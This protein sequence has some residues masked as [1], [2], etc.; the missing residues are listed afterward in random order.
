MVKTPH[1]PTDFVHAFIR[2]VA[3]DQRWQFIW[4]EGETDSILWPPYQQLDLHIAVAEPDVD[5]VRRDLHGLF[6]EFD[7]VRDFSQQEAPLKGWAGSAVLSDGTPL[8]YRVER[9]SQLAKVPRRWVN[10]MVDRSGGLLIPS[11]SFESSN[12]G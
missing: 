2:R 4:L 1:L 3:E 10:V 11:L 12:A 8:T 7:K 6:S 9:A 5:S